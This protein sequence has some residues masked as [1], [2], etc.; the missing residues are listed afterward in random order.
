M[1]EGQTETLGAAVVAIV[2]LLCL[3]KGCSYSHEEEMARI[4]RITTV[5]AEKSIAK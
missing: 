1:S 3:A 4:G 2:L 5:C